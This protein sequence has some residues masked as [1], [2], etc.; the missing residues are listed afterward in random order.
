MNTSINVLE[1]E[2]EEI[3]K[4]HYQL[5]SFYFGEF[6]LALQNRSLHYPLMNVDYSTGGL[7]DANTSLQMIIVIADKIYKD[8]SN[9]IEVKS[10]TLQVCRD[11]FNLLKKSTRWKKIGRIGNGNIDA[12]VERGKD[13]VAG[14]I[15][16][17][18]LELRDSN[19]ICNLPLNG[20]DYGGEFNFP[21]NPV[22]IENSNKTFIIEVQPN[23]TYVLPNMEVEIHIN[24]VYKESVTLITL[25]Q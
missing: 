9:L 4:A 6:T 15:L 19:G 16:R 12:F 7:N 3:Q 23:S 2:F 20:Y 13:E 5:N 21:C 1:R 17:F 22:T 11:I 14:H 24:G 10:D 18:N 8:N 25:D